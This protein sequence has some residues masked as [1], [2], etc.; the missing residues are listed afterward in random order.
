MKP[1]LKQSAAAMNGKVGQ[2]QA[3]VTK[4]NDSMDLGV[5]CT[6]LS[7]RI[8]GQMSRS[9]RKENKPKR[10]NTMRRIRVM[11]VTRAPTLQAAAMAPYL[12]HLSLLVLA[13]QLT[14]LPLAG[15]SHHVLAFL[16]SKL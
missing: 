13:I 3:K 1:W 6:Q 10:Y 7:S 12:H 8:S 4:Q 2:D 11:M 16:K 9:V 5:V 14:H 15:I